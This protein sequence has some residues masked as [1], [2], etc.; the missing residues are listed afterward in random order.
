MADAKIPRKLLDFVEDRAQEQVQFVIDLSHQ[1]SYSWNKEGT[2]RV[3]GMILDKVA[4][5]FS[6]HRVVEQTRVGNLHLLTN[7]PAGKSIYILAHMDTVFPPDHP[8][9]ECLV[10]EDRLHGP[11]T[12]D[13]KAGV[14]TVVYAVLALQEAGLLDR[15]PLTVIFGGDEEIGAITSR[16]VYEEERRK[17]LACLVVEGAGLEGEVVVSRNGKIGA[18]LECFGRDQHVGAAV[19]DK[20]SAILELAHKTIALEAL[21]GALPGARVNV[22]KVEGGLGPATIP[23]LASAQIDIRWEDQA[24][25]DPLMARIREA[26]AREVLPG[27]RSELSILN[28]RSAWPHTEGSQRLADL[29]REAGREIG[30]EIG[31]EHRRGT[32]DSNFFGCAGVPTVDG[33]GPICKGY[34][35]A[36]EFVY[37]PSIKARTALLATALVRIA[38]ELPG[39]SEPEG[40][41]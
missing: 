39:D 15:I 33:I 14:A 29:V 32:S 24:T 13:M 20:A 16:T 2:D 22:G 36:E 34:H 27:C 35:T 19:L 10:E 30:Q 1:N 21:N 11:G 5:A 26:V 9:R 28:E 40:P 7:T 8:F 37:I 41:L 18:R 25:R 12:G 3:A 31:Q 4:G 17:A 6:H 23:A 38:D